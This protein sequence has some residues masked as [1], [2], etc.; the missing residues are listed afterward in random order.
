MALNEYLRNKQKTIYTLVAIVTIPAFVLIWGGSGSAM[1]EGG[2]D[3]LLM[4][5]DGEKVTQHEFES[6]RDRLRAASGGLG[7]YQTQYMDPSVFLLRNQG[8]DLN[9]GTIALA[10]AYLNA[11]KA[12]GIRVSKK[13]MGTYVRRQLPVFAGI[14]DEKDFQKSY[15]GYLKDR[16][17][18]ADQ[19]MQGVQEFL[20][21]QRFLKLLDGDTL[22]MQDAAYANYA[23]EKATC[24]YQRLTVNVTDKMKADARQE[25]IKETPEQSEI[26]LRQYYDKNRENRRYWTQQKWILEYVMAPL[27]SFQPLVPSDADLEKYYNSHKSKYKDQAFAEAK[28]QVQNDMMDEARLEIAKRM[29]EEEVDVFINKTI[30]AKGEN[31]RVELA[32][33]DADADMK[34]F[35]IK[36]GVTGEQLMTVAEIEKLPEIGASEEMISYLK[37]MENM[38]QENVDKEVAINKAGFRRMFECKTGVFR[39]RVKDFTPARPRDLAS[40]DGKPDKELLEMLQSDII[41]DR[42]I[43]FARKEAETWRAK[44]LQNDPDAI[45]ELKT[46]TSSYEQLPIALQ[47]TPKDEAALVDQ[48]NEGGSITGVDIYVMRSRDIPSL[49][50]FQNAGPERERNQMIQARMTRGAMFPDYRGGGWM[51]KTGANL[52]AWTKS[53]FEQKKIAI[54]VDMSKKEE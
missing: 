2:S 19:F 18:T 25:F 4:Q 47:E 17:I 40:A 5:I 51:I 39:L 49:Q 36:T 27:S 7:Y 29:I 26:T 24:T 28:P 46:E 41:R 38:A 44:V 22:P 3:R 33:F 14:K 20:M 13:E 15:K 53:M 9:L 43:D 1:R 48:T 10:R 8:I 16:Q 11:A 12:S 23:V 30:S 54:L 34:R 32:D 45:K 37:Y 35:K 52:Y 50:D 42:A 31:G 21:I 6:F